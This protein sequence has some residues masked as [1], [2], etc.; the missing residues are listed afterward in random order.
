MVKSDHCHLAKLSSKELVENHED[1]NEFGG[2][3]I[4]NGL[5]KILRLLIIPKKNYPIAFIRTSVKKKNASFTGHMVQIKCVRDDLYSKTIS[6]YY[7]NDGNISIGIIHRKQEF[8]IPVIIILKALVETTD[9]QIYNKLVHGYSGNS[10]ISDR[11]E[12]LLRVSKNLSLHTKHQ[13]LAYLGSRF[14]SELNLLHASDISD[15]EVGEIFLREHICVHSKTN[16]DKL[17]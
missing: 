17:R 14:R 16:I 3:F 10:E 9:V 7:V 1:C 15:K 8:L 5:E 11:V 6:L 2:Y 4:I 13:C 12:V